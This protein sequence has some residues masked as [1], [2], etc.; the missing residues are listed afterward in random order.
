MSDR[1]IQ[2]MTPKQVCEMSGSD[3]ESLVE[4]RV[5]STL[6]SLA[7]GGSV[8]AG[9]KPSVAGDVARKV[10]GFIAWILCAM[11]SLTKTATVWSGKKI[12][13]KAVKEWGHFKA[14][15]EM[16]KK[17][18]WATIVYGVLMGS[19]GMAGMKLHQVNPDAVGWIV[20]SFKAMLLL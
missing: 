7:T 10:S 15:T 6:E 20:A 3:L 19:I 4:A 2:G 17:F 12:G 16:A 14:G 5:K 1:T 11:F 8:E 18:A 9:T 13:E